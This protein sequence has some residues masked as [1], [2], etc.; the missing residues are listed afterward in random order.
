LTIA[1]FPLIESSSYSIRFSGFR[2]AFFSF[3]AGMNSMNVNENRF[4]WYWELRCVSR[5]ESVGGGVDLEGFLVAVGDEPSGVLGSA[6]GLQD[7]GAVD[8]TI[9]C[10]DVAGG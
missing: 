6:V 10:Q 4:F 8:G 7:D 5:A 9:E 3:L 2:A 1:G